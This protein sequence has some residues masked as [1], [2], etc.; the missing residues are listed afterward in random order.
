M[1]YN[2]DGRV[3]IGQK[4]SVEMYIKLPDAAVEPSIDTP[5]PEPVWRRV[6]VTE[7]LDDPEL[8]ACPPTIQLHRLLKPYPILIFLPQMY[9]QC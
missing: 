9:N 8:W 5:L 1:V 6:L 4:D 3:T 2:A 7:D